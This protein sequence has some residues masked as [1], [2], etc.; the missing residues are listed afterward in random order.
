MTA[1]PAAGEHGTVPGLAAGSR[2]QMEVHT[3]RGMEEH[4]SQ[5][6]SVRGA[7][8]EVQVP[9]SQRQQRPLQLGA[10]VIASYSNHGKTGQFTARVA[11]HSRDGTSVYLESAAPLQARDRRDGFRLQMPMTPKNVRRLVP[12]TAEPEWRPD[13]A[14]YTVVDISEGGACLHTT[15]DTAAGETV[16]LL[17]DLYEQGELTAHLKVLN[18]EEHE[19]Y[20]LRRLH[21]R[22]AD[23]SRTDRNR[24]ARF[25]VRKQ[26]ELRRSGR[27]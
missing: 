16:E 23:L 2:I 20:R 27:L 26:I 1:S 3:S 9:I 22:L 5:V 13:N 6:E 18:V 7:V 10:K 14:E 12:G 21:C 25:L 8:V 11:G 19:G 24:I 17:I 4:V 15:S